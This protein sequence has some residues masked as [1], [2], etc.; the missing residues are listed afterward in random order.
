MTAHALKGDRERCLASGM[1]A[2]VAKPLQP[3]A[4][5]RVIEELMAARPSNAPDAAEASVSIQEAAPTAQPDPP[6]AMPFDYDSALE[7]VE[8]DHALLMNML[9]LYLDS[10]VKLTALIQDTLRSQDARGLERAAH[11]VK[12]AVGTLSAQRAFDAA[13]RLEHSAK[14]AD[15]NQAG[16]AWTA[17]ER[18]LAALRASIESLV[19][20]EKS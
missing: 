2:Y 14:A 10:S 6:A 18:E 7:R 19:K 11:T 16:E 15:F 9:G 4:L 3:A 8:G 20:Q 1:D 13:L 12:G 17:L 5:N